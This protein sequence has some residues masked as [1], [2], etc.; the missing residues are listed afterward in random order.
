MALHKA[1]LLPTAQIRGHTPKAILI[2]RGIRD[3]LK[4]LA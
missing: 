2:L 3:L 1:T 4:D